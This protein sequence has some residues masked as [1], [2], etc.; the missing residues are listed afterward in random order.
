LAAVQA[1]H[2]QLLNSEALVYEV[3][4]IPDELRRTE[5]FSVLTLAQ[6]QLKITDEVENLALALEQQG[7]RAMDAVHLALAS[8]AKADFFCTCDD[9]LCRRA[10]TLLG[11]S[12]KITTLLGLVL[13]ITQ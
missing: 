8:I 1:G 9:K 12:C 11:L 3:G 2:L 10:Q 4:R 7:I 13:E 6:T 5:V